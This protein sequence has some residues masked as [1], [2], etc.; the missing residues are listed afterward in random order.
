MDEMEKAAAP[1]FLP[2]A[3]ALGGK[4]LAWL[5]AGS[6][7]MGAL[8]AAMYGSTAWDMA[9]GLKGV[10]AKS[11]RRPMGF[12]GQG[13]MMPQQ[14]VLSSYSRYGPHGFAHMADLQERFLAFQSGIDRF[15]KEA[16]FDEED[17]EAMYAL[18]KKSMAS[19]GTVN[20]F[21]E[22]KDYDPQ[23]G[24]IINRGIIPGSISTPRPPTSWAGQQGISAGQAHDPNNVWWSMWKSH[25]N[26][27]NAYG[28]FDV[29]KEQ[30]AK[31]WDKTEY[32]RGQRYAKQLRNYE[33]EL[34]REQELMQ[35]PLH[36]RA[37]AERTAVAAEQKAQETATSP[38]VIQNLWRQAGGNPMSFAALARSTMNMEG[39]SLGEVLDEVRKSNDWLFKAYPTLDKFRQKE[40]LEEQ[41]Q[42]NLGQ[43]GRAGVPPS[44][45]EAARAE[46]Q[47][48]INADKAQGQGGG[49]APGV[50]QMEMALNA[51]RARYPG[52]QQPSALPG[53]GWGGIVPPREASRGMSPRQQAMEMDAQAIALGGRAPAP[54]DLALNQGERATPVANIQRGPVPSDLAKMGPGAAPNMPAMPP[55]APVQAPM[56]GGGGEVALHIPGR[57]MMNLP[58]GGGAVPPPSPG[59]A[60]PGPGT[61]VAA[62]KK[63]EVPGA[64]T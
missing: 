50:P 59:P 48:L 22:D 58:R 64:A 49:Q 54:V 25:W 35:N 40:A 30:A 34:A 41:R 2:A 57:G 5:G 45:A 16:G 38:N 14:G 51:F 55:G 53:G 9:K 7:V 3:L 11:P 39:S 61:E 62:G 29:G 28:L 36:A 1:M 4:A 44:P 32:E 12:P 15:C 26:P 31:W 52:A 21:V 24:M 8:N 47:A 37:R 6:K 23:T 27:L 43:E 17:R 60:A 33:R 42:A 63:P 56:P 20:P 13:G 10:F 18:V 19:S 46:A